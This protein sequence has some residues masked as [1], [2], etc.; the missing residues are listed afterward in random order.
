MLVLPVLAALAQPPA[1]TP[2]LTLTWRSP[3]ECPDAPAVERAV[4]AALGRPLAP[5]GARPIAVTGSLEREGLRGPYR[6]ALELRSGDSRDFRQFQAERC[7]LLAD[8]AA[9]VIA[10]AVDPSIDPGTRHAAPVAAP[11]PAAPSPAPPPAVTPDPTDIPDSR[12]RASS[13]DPN[14]AGERRLALLLRAG[15]TLDLGTLPGVAAPGVGFGLGLLTPRLRVDLDGTWLAPRTADPDP[16]R[17]LRIRV[18][19]WAA[20]L[21]ACARPRLGPV[22]FPT[23][24]GGQVGELL[25]D[26]VGVAIADPSTVRRLALGLVV[27]A[28]LRWAFL[29]GR[30][31]LLLRVDAVVALRRARF[32][33][34]GP[35]IV[36]TPAP[37]AL[38]PALA[39]E[40]RLP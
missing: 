14:L 5:A 11:P 12:P 17:D 8:A 24:L 4:E 34:D 27:G 13:A 35:G 6:L 10:V 31:A 30:L 19:L 32:A 16:T 28:G 40:V 25:G 18:G 7:E 1:V 38:Q 22:E 29:R 20:T 3:P 36:H 33:V 15:P 2:E 23:C 26:A 9:V 21:R 37:V 39:L